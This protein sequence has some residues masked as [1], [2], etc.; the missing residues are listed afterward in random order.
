MQGKRIQ[1]KE[2]NNQNLLRGVNSKEN[3]NDRK[4]QVRSSQNGYLVYGL[5][6]SL[7]NEIQNNAVSKS[8]T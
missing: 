6:F 4:M 1:T 2:L 5:V 8:K 3:G 7:Q